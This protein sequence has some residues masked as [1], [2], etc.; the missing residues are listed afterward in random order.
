MK[1]LLLSLLIPTLRLGFYL[2]RPFILLIRGN[3]SYFLCLAVAFIPICYCTL[4]FSIKPPYWQRILEN[5][6]ASLTSLSLF[7]ISIAL[8][9]I[10]LC[11]PVKIIYV[12]RRLIFTYL[13]KETPKSIWYFVSSTSYAVIR[14]LLFFSAIS[15]ISFIGNISINYARNESQKMILAA[16]FLIGILFFAY[17]I[18]KLF[19][20][21]LIAT[22]TK[23]HFFNALRLLLMM[24]ASKRYLAISSLVLMFIIPSIFLSLLYLPR[25]DYLGKYLE[26][27]YTL[28]VLNCVS[29]WFCLTQ[30]L[31]FLMDGLVEIE[32][33]VNKVAPVQESKTEI[34]ISNIKVI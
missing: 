4:H 32:L 2:C 21:V 28:M 15:L 22:M 12:R 16:I 11:I 25:F 20:I 6:Q 29:I 27:P 17:K 18:A 34:Q 10:F 8:L 30:C 3:L 33:R 1:K 26:L 13:L 23:S 14:S 31:L 19:L 24:R 7:I 5:W 9:L